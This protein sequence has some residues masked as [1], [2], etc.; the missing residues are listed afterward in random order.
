MIN[1]ARVFKMDRELF[2]L[3]YVSI[4]IYLL[5]IKN[6][7]YSPTKSLRQSAERHTIDEYVQWRPHI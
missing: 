7:Y 5:Y 6:S 4:F 2:D 1:V 3:K